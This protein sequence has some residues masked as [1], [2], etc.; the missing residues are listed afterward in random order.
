MFGVVYVLCSSAVPLPAGISAVPVSMPTSESR[1][2]VRHNA[3]A[4]LSVS[5]FHFSYFLCRLVVLYPRHL[6][7]SSGNTENLKKISARGLAG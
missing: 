6:H 3:H 1:A 4:Q 7:L 2:A 5:H